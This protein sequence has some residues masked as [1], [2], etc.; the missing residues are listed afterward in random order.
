MTVADSLKQY[1]STRSRKEQ[2]VLGVAAMALLAALLY[3]VLLE[4]GLA[5]RRQLGS[6]LP[7]LRAQVEDMQQQQKEIALLRKKLGTVSKSADLK[8]LLQSSV[9]RTSFVNAL[10][11]L[12]AVAGDK[13]AMLASPV[14]F[15]D[16]LAWVENLQREL[17]IRLD[18]CR[19]SALDLPG[20]VRIEATF[21]T[22]QSAA[23]KTP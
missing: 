23:R 13:A 1:W 15:D 12:D 14:V 6:A 16:W 18:A 20:M 17:G 5:A 7:R 3:L 9:A 22:G 11:R 21:I 19:I 10:E 4:P 2:V 8:A